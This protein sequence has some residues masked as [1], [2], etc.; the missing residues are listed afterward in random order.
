MPIE[1]AQLRLTTSDASIVRVVD[2]PVGTDTII[3]AKRGQ[4]T[5]RGT[6]IGVTGDNPPFADVII[7]A[8]AASITVDSTSVTFRNIGD[9]VRLHANVFDTNGVLIDSVARWRSLNNAV[10][11]I[12]SITGKLLARASGTTQ[13]RAIVDVDTATLQ[14]SVVQN[15]VRYLFSAPT[16]TINSLNQDTVITVRPLDA[17]GSFIPHSTAGLPAPTFTS[18]NT[19]VVTV[20]PLTDSTFRVSSL[21]NDTTRVRI[22]AGILDT[23]LF[24]S[25]G[26][27]ATSVVIQGATADTIDALQDTVRLR[28]RAFDARTNEVQGRSVIWTSLNTTVVTVDANGLVTGQTLG[29][30]LVTAR[31]DAALDTVPITVQNN[32][33]S[34]SIFSNRLR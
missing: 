17:G 1:G 21:A 11:S 15:L 34:I 7:T 8:V 3:V 19:G 18:K 31:L 20:T 23:T 29:T 4:A 16:L 22:V 10:A 2:V 24:V 25:V 27:Q 5:V 6:L 28:G 9:T 33:R 12:D 13:I 30:A 32:P 14:V 26:Q